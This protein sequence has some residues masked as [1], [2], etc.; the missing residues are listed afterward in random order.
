MVWGVFCKLDFVVF[1]FFNLLVGFDFGF[2][3]EVVC[4][5][6]PAYWNQSIP[7][8][9]SLVLFLIFQCDQKICSGKRESKNIRSHCAVKSIQIVISI[10]AGSMNPSDWRLETIMSFIYN[11]I[12]WRR[13]FFFIPLHYWK[14][15]LLMKACGWSVEFSS[16][17]FYIWSNCCTLADV[18]QLIDRGEEK[19]LKF[20]Y[21][22]WRLDTHNP[23]SLFSF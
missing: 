11:M 18:T 21:R 4:L 12:F 15:R 10:R 23:C 20:F 1:F 22:V 6:Q 13:F 9:T 3:G 19:A 16:L 2:G 14:H 17:C 7:R 8:C 5:F